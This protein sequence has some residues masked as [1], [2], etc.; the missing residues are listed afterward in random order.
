MPGFVNFWMSKKAVQESFAALAKDKDFGKNNDLAGKTIMVEF[1][2]P[3]PFKLF[4]IG[5]LMS[6]TIGESFARLHEASGAKVERLSYGGDV[7]LHVA[8]AIFGVLAR[9]EEIAKVRAGAEKMQL[10]FWADAYV[11]GS[12]RYEDDEAAKRAIDEL[13]KTIFER[14]N[15]EINELY[16]WGRDISIRAFKEMFVRLGTTFS[17]NYW[18]SEVMEDGVKMVEEGLSKKILEKSDGAVVFKGEP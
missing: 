8:K 12:A 9:K 15:K 2:D 7:G 14:S 18:E 6:N 16:L 10:V 4:H 17:K 5:H 3:N 1:T 11:S 13:N